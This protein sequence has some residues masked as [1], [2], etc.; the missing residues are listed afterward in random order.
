MENKMGYNYIKI[1]QLE[2]DMTGAL[3]LP[4]V[5]AAFCT[6][7]NTMATITALRAV[8]ASMAHAG[9]IKIK[10]GTELVYL[11]TFYDV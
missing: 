6:S 4:S 5:G 3:E 1:G 8:N 7:P 11:P 2:S 10:I 9:S